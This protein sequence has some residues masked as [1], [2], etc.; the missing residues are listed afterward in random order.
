MLLSTLI[1]IVTKLLLIDIVTKLLLIDIVTKLLLID[2]V[3]KLL[4]SKSYRT[5]DPEVVGDS[6]SVVVIQTTLVLRSGYSY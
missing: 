4:L 1:D 3:T 5:S 2:I 6:F